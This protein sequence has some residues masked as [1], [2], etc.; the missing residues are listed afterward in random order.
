MDT[1]QLFLYSRV[2][3]SLLL[4][5]AADS[6]DGSC[7]FI[8][9]AIRCGPPTY[10]TY[11][12]KESWI[13]ILGDTNRGDSGMNNMPNPRMAAHI[14]PMPTTVRQDA[15]P[16]MLRVPIEMQYATSIPNVMN[17]TCA[18]NHP[19]RTNKECG[20]TNIGRCRY[21]TSVSWCSE[22]KL[23]DVRQCSANSRRCGLGLILR[24]R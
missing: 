11:R 12:P 23:Q 19:R 8:P 1:F 21:A 6:G 4:G 18:V 15:A 13:I 7:G 2:I 5:Q 22:N 14:T 24:V 17:T 20:W 3:Q 10:Y 16:L 9:M